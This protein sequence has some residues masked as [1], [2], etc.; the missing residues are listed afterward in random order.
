LQW[1]TA[2]LARLLARE[3]TF[4]EIMKQAQKQNARPLRAGRL[5]FG[6][7]N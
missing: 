7:V 6:S 1:F 2:W 4:N 5:D 3:K